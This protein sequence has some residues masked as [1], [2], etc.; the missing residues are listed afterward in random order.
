[1]AAVNFCQGETGHSL[2]ANVTSA[3]QNPGSSTQNWYLTNTTGT[4]VGSGTTYTL[5]AT[6]YNT[7]GT[8]TYIYKQVNITDK[9]C[10]DSAQ[11]SVSVTVNTTPSVASVTISGD[12]D[13]CTKDN[14]TDNKISLTATPS[15]AA[16]NGTTV[17]YEWFKDA[18]TSSIQ[19]G[20]L[21]YTSDAAD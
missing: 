10:K 16:A 2:T 20:C 5:P 12:D 3:A 6:T 13:Y 15:P 7:A 18:G 1:M 8:Y 14:K 9:G 11:K 19:S 17:T 21:L 4:A